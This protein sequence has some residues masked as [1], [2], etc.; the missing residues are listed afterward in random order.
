[1]SLTTGVSPAVF[2]S[3]RTTFFTLE[4]GDILSP[5]LGFIILCFRSV[6]ALSSG[7]FSI[8]LD[9]RRTSVLLFWA[10]LAVSSF[11]LV[12]RVIFPVVGTDGFF[13]WIGL[14]I[15]SVLL[16]L[17]RL[18]GLMVGRFAV[19]VTGGFF[20]LIELPI[21]S[22]LLELIRLPGLVVGRFVV[23]VTGGFFVL[24]ELPIRSV[25]LELIR[26][27]GLMV[28]R[29]VVVEVIPVGFLL[30]K[31]LLDGLRGVE[32]VGGRGVVVRLGVTLLG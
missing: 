28:G 30:P 14:P 29:F 18:P 23:V 25:L 2:L 11:G 4:L 7:C 8:A 32:A 31:E 9:F 10:V 27:P 5:T 16:E 21:R 17:I 15:R 1:M 12:L 19:V 24:I 22:V 3:S 13:R 26:L 6:S 20:V